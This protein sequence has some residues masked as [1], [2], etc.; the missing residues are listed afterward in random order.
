MP[1]PERRALP[2]GWI[3]A[4]AATMLVVVVVVVGIM[5]YRQLFP[6]TP[7]AMVSVIMPTPFGNLVFERDDV[8]FETTPK[9]SERG[10]DDVQKHIEK[11]MKSPELTL[12]IYTDR[13]QSTGFTVKAL[14]S[15]VEASFVLDATAQASV[16]PKLRALFDDLGEIPANSRVSG[17]T[18]LDYRIDG[19]REEI[20]RVIERVLLEAYGVA[21]DA[22]LYFQ[23]DD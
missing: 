23:I 21:P 9:F 4:T 5:G 10:I 12:S 8:S 20:S 17:I 11:L 6:T 16:E 22:G 13:S 1:D 2:L 18:L 15:G 3:V 14:D 7:G 19:S